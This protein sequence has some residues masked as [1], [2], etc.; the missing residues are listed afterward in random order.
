MSGSCVIEI[1]L[2]DCNGTLLVIVLAQ[3]KVKVVVTSPSPKP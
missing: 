3:R 1:F 2:G